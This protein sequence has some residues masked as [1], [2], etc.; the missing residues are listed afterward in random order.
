[1]SATLTERQARFLIDVA[2]SYAQMKDDAAAIDALVRS[3]A[4]A[5]D[6]LRRHRLTR[7]LIPQLLTRERRSSD[8]RALAGR[9]HLLA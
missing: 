3:E 4:I 2:R 9:C 1:M 7:E 5:P 6:E 8:L